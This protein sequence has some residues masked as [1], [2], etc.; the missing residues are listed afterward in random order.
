[1]SIVLKTKGCLELSRRLEMMFRV[2]MCPHSSLQGNVWI[3][4]LVAVPAVES[5]V[6]VWLLPLLREILVRETPGRTSI[7]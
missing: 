4:G 1:M 2:S 3:N 5:R 6:L 7:L